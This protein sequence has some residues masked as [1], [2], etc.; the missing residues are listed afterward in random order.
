MTTAK[1]S[2]LRDYWQKTLRLQDWDVTVDVVRANEISGLGQT[3]ISGS[4]RSATV[5]ILDERDAEARGDTM[6]SGRDLEVTLVH[7]LMHLHFHDINP[8]IDYN[9][10]Q[11]VAQER[12]IDTLAIA[13]VRMARMVREQV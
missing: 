1:L 4:Y 9:S 8:T 11:G 10:S 5:K 3:E 12:A 7:E 2:R 6:P 13:F